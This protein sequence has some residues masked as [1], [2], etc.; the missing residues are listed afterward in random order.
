MC[1][2]IGKL[3]LFLEWCSLQVIGWKWLFGVKIRGRMFTAM[4]TLLEHGTRK[5][6][7]YH[8]TGMAPVRSHGTRK[9]CHYHDTTASACQGVSW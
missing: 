1:F 9:G 5:G 7:H 6:C 3:W 8:D 2:S 4:K